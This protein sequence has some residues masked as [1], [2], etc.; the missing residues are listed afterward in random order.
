MTEERL[1]SKFA[2][3][4]HADLAGSSA[5]VQQNEELAH[6]LIQITKYK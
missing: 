4:L 3:T 2:I 5:L 6:K 1:L